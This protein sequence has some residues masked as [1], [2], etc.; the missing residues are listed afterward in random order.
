MVVEV[1]RVEELGTMVAKVSLNKL[2]TTPPASSTEDGKATDST[3]KDAMYTGTANPQ[4]RENIDLHRM[5]YRYQQTLSE[6]EG[7]VQAQQEQF[8]D[9]YKTYNWR[10]THR[11]LDDI[12][13]SK[14]FIDLQ[15]QRLIHNLQSVLVDE[16][17][18]KFGKTKGS[19]DGYTLMFRNGWQSGDVRKP[20]A[21][22]FQQY[23]EDIYRPIL[24]ALLF[25]EWWEE[26]RDH[27]HTFKSCTI[28]VSE[29]ADFYGD[30]I[31]HMHIDGKI[32]L[33][34]K[35]NYSQKH[36]SRLLFSIVTEALDD[37]ENSTA[38]KY[39]TT[40]YPI[41]QP[42]VG[43]RN[44]KEF[45]KYMQALYLD[46]GLENSGLPR[47]HY[48][49]PEELVYRAVPGEVL[50][51]KTHAEPDLPQPIHAEPN[52]CPDRH[53]YVFDWNNLI[54]KKEG[55]NKYLPSTEVPEAAILKSMKP[56]ADSSSPLFK[57]RLSLVGDT[58]RGLL[59]RADQYQGGRHAVEELLEQI[60]TALQQ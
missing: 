32:G 36:A 19:W 3:R 25:G 17:Y 9:L 59:E 29:S 15:A 45:H 42:K 49:M 20:I 38:L 53:L 43:F 27:W 23:L 60:Q 16:L 4:N 8:R 50:L 7:G 24:F 14:L 55:T 47:P 39:G 54:H 22:D 18:E 41:W 11:H 58:A 1:S 33:L 56:L 31:F 30:N 21:E 6:A 35:K 2:S 12:K 13:T 51:H 52:P 26:L 34:E 37:V 40:V 46:R 57:Q 5:R 10:A 48:E 44:N 28:K